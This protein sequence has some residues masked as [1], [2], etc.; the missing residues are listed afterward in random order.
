MEGAWIIDQ[1]GGDVT[2]AHRVTRRL[3][4][5]RTPYQHLEIYESPLFGRMLVLDGAV[6]TTEADEFAYHEMLAHPPLCTHPGP[7]RILIIGGGD[8]GLLEEVLKHPVERVVMVEIDEAVIR[9]GRRYLGTICG[10]AFEDPR[11][12]LVIGD[13]IAYARETAERFDVVLVDSTDPQGPA[14]GLF[15]EEFY[16]HLAHCLTPDGLVA[17]QS[18]SA[19]YQQELIRMVRR[20]LRAAFPIVRTYL[21]SVAAYPGGLWSFTMGS[22]RRDPLDVAPEAIAPRIEE[23]RLA[24][25]TPAG[26][27]AAFALPPRLRGEVEGA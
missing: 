10:R 14:T 18:G 19:V 26:H 24:Y 21:A 23:L 1:G 13:G 7:R 15:A 20:H 12:Q 6:Q 25:Y 22:L 8:G 27:H 3:F 11:L 4:E 16:A 17:V 9:A 5:E 2:A